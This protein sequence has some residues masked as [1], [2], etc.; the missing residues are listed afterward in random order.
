MGIEANLQ[1]LSSFC[2]HAGK[3][4]SLSH[5]SSIVED[6]IMQMKYLY[7]L[8]C[9]ITSHVGTSIRPTSYLCVVSEPRAGFTYIMSD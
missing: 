3:S 9:G 2:F 6:L 5:R 1:H 8:F 4:L 7:S